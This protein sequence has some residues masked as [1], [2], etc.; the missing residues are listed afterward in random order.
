LDELIHKQEKDIGAREKAID[1]EFEV[2]IK[3][4]ESGL[5][6]IQDQKVNIINKISQIEQNYH[7]VFF[8]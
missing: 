2:D 6:D 4:L 1:K 7:E 8:E 5:Q 3:E